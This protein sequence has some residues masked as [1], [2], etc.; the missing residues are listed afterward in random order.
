[1]RYHVF[2]RRPAS[3]YSC[4]QLREGSLRAGRASIVSA[5][6]RSLG[7]TASAKKRQVAPEDAGS[8]S[9]SSS[10]S[11]T[12][13][14]EREPEGAPAAVAPSRLTSQELYPVESA[15]AVVAAE[16]AAAAAEALRVVE[17][18]AAE[19]EQQRL[20]AERNLQEASAAQRHWGSAWM[21]QVE[22]SQ[23][24]A[25]AP[26]QDASRQQ[27]AEQQAPH[28]AAQEPGAATE[29]SQGQGEHSDC[30]AAAPEQSAAEKARAAARAIYGERC[31]HQLQLS[32]SLEAC[33]TTLST[34]RA[35]SQLMARLTSLSNALQAQC[36]LLTLAAWSTH[37]LPWW[38][39]QLTSPPS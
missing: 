30:A 37:G 27:G 3:H 24:P 4:R 5:S 1:M 34:P 9:S 17:E 6:A 33:S 23:H 2:D 31:D 20:Q 10:S 13:A 7:S 14:H 15:A 39:P 32:F 36:A 12:S 38:P 35:D 22:P 19:A 25:Q 29:G 8:R 16:A 28:A 11:N 18:A 26:V 21:H